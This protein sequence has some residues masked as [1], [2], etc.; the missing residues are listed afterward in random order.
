[1]GRSR[2]VGRKESNIDG[3]ERSG[4]KVGRWG[5]EGGKDEGKMTSGGL[6]SLSLYR[7]SA[8]S[9]L[10]GWPPL[11]SVDFWSVYTS[12]Q[13][14]LWAWGQVRR[15]HSHNQLCSCASPCARVFISKWQFG[16]LKLYQACSLGAECPWPDKS[17][18]VFSF[19]PMRDQPSASKHTKCLMHRQ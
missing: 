13:P 10:V 18:A 17:P 5:E 11:S 16:M 6:E 19:R 2:G 4:S 8:L 12:L 9:S 1:M 14:L 3:C 15:S 7:T